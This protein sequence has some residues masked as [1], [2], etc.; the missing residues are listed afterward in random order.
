MQTHLTQGSLQDQSKRAVRTD[1][2]AHNA[3]CSRPYHQFGTRIYFIASE[4]LLEGSVAEQHQII[5]YFVSTQGRVI[6][7]ICGNICFTYLCLVSFSLSATLEEVIKHLES[8][9]A[10]RLYPSLILLHPSTSCLSC[11]PPSYLST[12]VLLLVYL[13]PPPPPRV[14]PCSAAAPRRW[15]HQRSQSKVSGVRHSH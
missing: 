10:S 15:R 13:L 5:H 7:G 4:W 14:Y 8:L 12:L 11:R 2:Y 6:L 1:L 3:R 9:L